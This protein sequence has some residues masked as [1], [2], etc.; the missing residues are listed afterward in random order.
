MVMVV[1][2]VAVMMLVIVISILA[3]VC[4]AMGRAHSIQSNGCE[5]NR[6]F[7]QGVPQNSDHN[8][9]MPRTT[10]SR[11]SLNNNLTNRAVTTTIIINSTILYQTLHPTQTFD[12]VDVL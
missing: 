10:A 8:A 11:P 4:V 12:F 3:R 2:R 6:K 5:E 1:F 7:G 9:M